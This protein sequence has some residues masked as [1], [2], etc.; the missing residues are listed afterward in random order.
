MDHMEDFIEALKGAILAKAGDAEKVTF[1]M[2][3]HW[4]QDLP[5]LHTTFGSGKRQITVP[6]GFNGKET[7][8]DV[9]RYAGNIIAA[10]EGAK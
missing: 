1:E 7:D 9:E 4:S 10:F 5:V 2:A 3:P 6:C 8:A